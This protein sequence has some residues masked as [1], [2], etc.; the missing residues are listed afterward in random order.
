MDTGHDIAVMVGRSE[1]GIDFDSLD[2]KKVHIIILIVWNPSIP[3]L[4]NHLFAGLAQ[5]LRK[6][7]FRKRL[8]EAKNRTELY[9]VVSEVELTLPVQDHKI[10][11]RASLLWKLQEVE[12]QK[13]K[14]AGAKQKELQKISKAFSTAFAQQPQ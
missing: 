3:G 1:E 10:I 2:H 4:F 12:I 14:A 9:Q 13:K 7:G 8:I 5:F 6:P 11:S